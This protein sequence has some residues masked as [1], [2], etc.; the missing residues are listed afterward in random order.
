MSES[1]S[2][3]SLIGDGG[4][5]G[6]EFAIENQFYSEKDKK[7]IMSLTE[8]QREEILAERAAQ[9][10]RK[11]QGQN[12]RRMLMA[13]EKES[14]SSEKK[15]KATDL[16]ESPRKSS[17]QKTTLGGRKVG[18]TSGAIE[19]YKRQ[20]EEKGLRDQQRR[21]EGADRKDRR[22]RSSSGGRG[23]SADAEGE[24]DLE[25][26]EGKLKVDDY[27]LRRAEPA[28]YNDVR[29][30]TLP[31]H[32]FADY[33]FHPG[34][35]EAV[36]DCY[37]RLASKPKPNGDMGYELALIKGNLVTLNCTQSTNVDKGVIEKEGWDYA[38]E[39]SNQKKVVTNQHIQVAIEG[40]VKDFHFNG[41]SNSAITEVSRFLL[42]V[43]SVI[44]INRRRLPIIRTS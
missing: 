28:D 4:P 27:R 39:K 26:D 15:R 33:C 12:L 3:A 6:P 22:A 23:S 20:R 24:S 2:D 37:V 29:R 16:E 1:N 30:A 41:I 18:E 34:F 32:A 31:R 25:W 36:R 43:N 9:L 14:K 8:V 11:L 10:E 17:R 21:R 38:M 44:N 5:D 19:A 42:L 35:P 13:R 7:E 40:T